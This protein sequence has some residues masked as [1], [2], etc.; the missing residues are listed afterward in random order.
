MERSAGV[1]AAPARLERNLLSVLLDGLIGR[2]G[3]I[4]TATDRA[5]QSRVRDCRRTAMENSSPD[6]VY[7]MMPEKLMLEGSHSGES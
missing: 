4:G 2:D 7:G 6:W 5:L 1:Q 3:A